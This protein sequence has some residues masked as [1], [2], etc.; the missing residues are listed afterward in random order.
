MAKGIAHCTC[1]KCGKAFTREMVKRNR[2]EANNWQSWAEAN[3]TECGDCYA[4]RKAAERE[5]ANQ[6]AAEAA[7]SQ[8]LPELTGSPKQVAWAETIR[9]KRLQSI[10]EAMGDEATWEPHQ[11]QFYDWVTGHTA[12]SWW[13]DRRPDYYPSFLRR[14]AEEFQAETGWQPEK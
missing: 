11:K 7:K 3:Y 5:A 12:A 14:V 10:R 1:A 8:E 2:E 9:Q 4:A 6:A 13:I